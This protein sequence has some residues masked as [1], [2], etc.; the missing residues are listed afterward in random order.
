MTDTKHSDLPPLPGPLYLGYSADQMHAYARAAI[1]A[2]APAGEPV[3]WVTHG[4][5]DGKQKLEFGATSLN[6]EYCKAHSQWV[7]EPLYAAPVPAAAPIPNGMVVAPD[8][9][10]YA[11]M[12][13]GLYV[14][15]HSAAGEAPELAISIATEAQKAGRAVGDERDNEPGAQVMPEYIAVRLC[16]ANVTGL[17]ALEGQLRHL[18]RVHFPESAAAPKPSLTDDQIKDLWA[19]E[20]MQKFDSRYL[21]FARAIE[22]ASGP[23]A[24]LVEALQ[25]ALAVIDD[26]L[27]YDHNGDPW[28]ED[29]RTMG[30]MDI[31]DY[32]HDGRLE[33]ARAALAAA[34]VG[35]AP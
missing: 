2:A 16:F 5:K 31:N 29:A 33:N 26:Y 4:T 21:L 6:P 10:G 8:Y 32:K 13:L 24:A 23:N 27:A 11:H 14:I 35:E 9:R 18:R 3:A 7:W 15:N 20:S 1:A 17:D 19:K 34:G 28:T 12:G 30:E 25:G 22:A